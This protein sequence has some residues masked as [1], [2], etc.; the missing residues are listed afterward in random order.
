MKHS[1][2]LNLSRLRDSLAAQTLPGIYPLKASVTE[3]VN[4]IQRENVLLAR[5]YYALI[6]AVYFDNGSTMKHSELVEHVLLSA[7]HEPIIPEPLLA[8]VVVKTLKLMSAQPKAFAQ[9][10]TQ[11][12]LSSGVFAFL[13]FPAMFGYFTSVEGCEQAGQ[14]LM[15]L[16]SRDVSDDLLHHLCLSFLFSCFSFTDALWVNV[17]ERLWDVGPV[18]DET[19]YRALGKAINDCLP[20]VSGPVRA[21]IHALLN[22]RPQLLKRVFVDGFLKMSLTNWLGFSEHGAVFSSGAQVLGYLDRIGSDPTALFLTSLLAMDV[23][24]V[25]VLPSFIVL[26]D[27][28]CELLV[29][30]R[31]DLEVMVETFEPNASQIPTFEMLRDEVSSVHDDRL[32]AMGFTFFAPLSR[33]RGR[34]YPS[35]FQIPNIPETPVA[36]EPTHLFEEVAK[37]HQAAVEQEL[38]ITRQHEYSVALSL[39]KTLVRLRSAYFEEYITREVTRTVRQFKGNIKDTIMEILLESSD[40]RLVLPAFIAIINKFHPADFQIPTHINNRFISIQKAKDQPDWSAVCMTTHATYILRLIPILHRRRNLP[41][42]QL[43]KIISFIMSHIHTFCDYVSSKLACEIKVVDVCRD[44]LLASQSD[45]LIDAFLF[46]EKIVFREEPFLK[47][48]SFRRTSEWNTFFQ[49]MWSLIA[50]DD[51]LLQECLQLTV[52]LPAKARRTVS[53]ELPHYP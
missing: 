6:F 17:S 46:F 33:D 26:A 37:L 25:P 11:A 47:N 31:Y 41:V 5:A 45:H 15:D 49:I 22:G 4:E 1:L 12:K 16:V 36:G 19:I 24:L 38:V 35:L 32:A 44:V 39:Q 10:L 2:A 20:L 40:K 18:R 43:F 52:S 29:F 48:L 13:T 27:L 23:G 9:A 7:G 14:L 28:P 3:R 53:H 21:L 42:G 8:Q 51:S 34:V 30:S 50:Q